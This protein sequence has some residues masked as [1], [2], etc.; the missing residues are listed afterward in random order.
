MYGFDSDDD[1]VCSLPAQGLRKVVTDPRAIPFHWYPSVVEAQKPLMASIRSI[2]PTP[3]SLS[4]PSNMDSVA[5]HTTQPSESASTAPIDPLRTMGL[6]HPVKV[7]TKVPPYSA[8]ILQ[9]VQSYVRLTHTSL[10]QEVSLLRQF[11]TFV[12]TYSEIQVFTVGC[13]M[14]LFIESSQEDRDLKN[15][16]CVTMAKNLLAIIQ[17]EADGGISGRTGY[18]AYIQAKELQCMEDEVNHAPDITHAALVELLTKCHSMPTRNTLWTMATT[19]GR[20]EDLAHVRAIRLVLTQRSLA[21]D[22]GKTKTARRIAHRMSQTYPWIDGVNLTPGQV[23]WFAKK[24]VKFVD[25]RSLNAYLSEY[26]AKADISPP[27][28]TYSFRRYAIQRFA[29]LCSKDNESGVRVTDWDTVISFTGHADATMP[30]NVYQRLSTA[31]VQ[32]LLDAQSADL[33]ASVMELPPASYDTAA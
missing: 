7:R 1:E 20:G 12:D 24:D 25:N 11:H 13:Q 15:S 19:S 4:I 33:D 5:T 10:R 21:V 18:R 8:E 3:N 28:T 6:D 16:S 27:Y 29:V 31:Q 22:W 32:A 9:R 26:C 2:M 30:K 14:A 23:D 17:R